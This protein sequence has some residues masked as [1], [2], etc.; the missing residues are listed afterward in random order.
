MVELRTCARQGGGGARAGALGGVLGGGRD[1]R[2]RH[3]V[4]VF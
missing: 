2:R 3:G 4:P 1:G